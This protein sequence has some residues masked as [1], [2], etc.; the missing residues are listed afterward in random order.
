METTRPMRR[1]APAEPALRH[2]L[3]VQLLAS[4]VLVAVG[5]ITATAWLAVNGTS[6]D[7]PRA[8]PGADDGGAHLRR[9][10]GFCGQPPPLGWRRPCGSRPG[11]A[12]RPPDR[13]DHTGSPA[14]RRL[15]RT[16]STPAAGETVRGCRSVDGRR[17][18]SATCRYRPHRLP[19][20]RSVPTAGRGAGAAA[21][22]GRGGGRLYPPPW[23]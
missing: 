10:V 13:P 21:T 6:G 5:A 12:D 17:G 1:R 15:G 4:S 8:G 16:G 22:Q 3:F 23:R 2:S 20:G 11:A 7:P 19:G 18:A 14:D 9:V